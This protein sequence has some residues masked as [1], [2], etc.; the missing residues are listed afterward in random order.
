MLA[1]SSH[2][3]SRVY[4]LQPADVSRL[5]HVVYY[6]DRLDVEQPFGKIEMAAF[7]GRSVYIAPGVIF[8]FLIP[9]PID[10]IPEIR[11][12]AT[13]ICKARADPSTHKYE[14]P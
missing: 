14:H 1:T 3:A 6:L 4:F 2:R 13:T 7:F 12:N 11:S 9:V 5:I 10:Q 8:F